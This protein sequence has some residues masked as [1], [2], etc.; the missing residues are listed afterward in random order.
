MQDTVTHHHIGLLRW[1]LLSNT[2]K[3]YYGDQS[4]ALVNG[5]FSMVMW[6]IG[7]FVLYILFE[8]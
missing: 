4:H 1:L 2:E 5:Y 8:E 7:N 3:L 6:V